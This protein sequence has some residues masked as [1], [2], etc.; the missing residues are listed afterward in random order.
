MSSEATPP[1]RINRLLVAVL[2]MRYYTCGLYLSQSIA[3]RVW[4]SLQKDYTEATERSLADRP[5][6]HSPQVDMLTTPAY[7]HIFH[8]S[9]TP[10]HKGVN[11]DENDLRQ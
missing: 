7:F 5:A 4:V 1:A 2:L 3:V 10:A 8:P 11:S 9:P 6:Q